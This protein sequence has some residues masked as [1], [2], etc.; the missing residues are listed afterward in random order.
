MIDNIIVGELVEGVT[1]E[2]LGILPTEQ[3]IHITN[4]KA[5]ELDYFLPKLL[6]HATLFRSTSEVKKIAK[7][8]DTSTKIIDPLSLHLWRSIN[9]PE[10][11]FFKI[12]KRSFWLVVG[13]LNK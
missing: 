12:G 2:M 4:D 7:V 13:N 1:H 11:T 9:E 5:N 10:F 3:T 8:R 6:V